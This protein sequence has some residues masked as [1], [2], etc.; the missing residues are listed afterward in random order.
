MRLAI[1]AH[2]AAEPRTEVERAL[3]KGVKALSRLISPALTAFRVSI[4]PDASRLVSSAT[5]LPNI[6]WESLSSRRM[7]SP[8]IWPAS[9]RR[10][11]SCFSV[12][13]CLCCPLSLEPGWLSEE[14]E[15]YFKKKGC[16]VDLHPT[17]EA[18]QVWNE[19]E[20]KVIGMFH[21]TC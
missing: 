11:V 16:S 7:Q 18:I 13:R 3:I 20:G 10:Y 9:R 21:V 4:S 6:R 19:A 17:P 12:A 14:A 8:R 2:R 15:G 5:G 1:V